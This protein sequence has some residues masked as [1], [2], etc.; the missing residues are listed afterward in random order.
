LKARGVLKKHDNQ[1]FYGVTQKGFSWLWLEICSDNYFKNP[2]I[3]RIIKNDFL[4]LAAQPSIIEEAFGMIQGGLS[5]L[6]QQLAI[7]S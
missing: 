3:S 1:S 6:T 4:Q 5:Q 2:M 7:N